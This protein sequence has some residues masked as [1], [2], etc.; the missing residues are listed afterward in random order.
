MYITKIIHF[1]QLDGDDISQSFFDRKA[2]LNLKMCMQESLICI[3]VEDK[4]LISLRCPLANGY[5]PS[6]GTYPSNI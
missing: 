3:H 6:R 2:I 1:Q 5:N 4:G